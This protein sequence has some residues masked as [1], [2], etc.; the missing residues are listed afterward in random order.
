MSHGVENPG[1]ALRS[2]GRRAAIAAFVAVAVAGCG[3]GGQGAQRGSASHGF[4]GRLSNGLIYVEWTVS[5]SQLAGTL[6]QDVLQRQRHGPEAVRVD[7]AVLTGSVMGDRLIV[8]INGAAKI[9]GVF[10]GA[11]LVLD[12]PDPQHTTLV[13]GLRVGSL[14]VVTMRPTTAPVYARVLATLRR[15]AAVTNATAHP[16]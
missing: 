4:L 15:Q 11:Q 9:A 13:G 3:G 6:E 7:H 14:D 16:N 2:L 10:R 8:S 1:V 5:G 12:Y